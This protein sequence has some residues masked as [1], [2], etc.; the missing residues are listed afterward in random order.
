MFILLPAFGKCRNAVRR[1]CQH[2]TLLQGA[3]LSVLFSDPALQ[4][5]AQ[6]AHQFIA[7]LPQFTQ[8]GNT[9]TNT[10]AEAYDTIGA[11]W[12]LSFNY[13]TN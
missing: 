6:R 2:K 1:G 12:Y 7:A 9:G 4:C 3:R 11:Q 8:Y 13:Y 5:S 10:A